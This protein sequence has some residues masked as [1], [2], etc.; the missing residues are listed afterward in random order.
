LSNLNC[1]SLTW[2]A[3]SSNVVASVPLPYPTRLAP[4]LPPRRLVNPCTT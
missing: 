3:T 4:R 1:L 2:S